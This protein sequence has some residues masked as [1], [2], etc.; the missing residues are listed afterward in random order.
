MKKI[1]IFYGSTT[2][3]TYKVAQ[4]L[5]ALLKVSPNDT[6]DISRV[7]PAAVG[8]YDVLLFGSSTWGAGDL[9]EDWFDFSAAIKAMNLSDKT[10][11]VFGTGNEKM[12][13]TFCNAVGKISDM[14]ESTGARL[15]GQFNAEGYT[16]KSSA[17]QMEGLPLMKGLVL[18]EG[19]H[20]EL[21]D[22]RLKEWAQLII[23][24]TAAE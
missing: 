5:A 20:P 16:F 2:G 22:K 17:A 7:A 15:I 13:K 14:A 12:V 24:E 9:Q 23:E 19:N 3:N 10:I 8:E 21:T 6:Y 1:G 11:A 18:D 4:K